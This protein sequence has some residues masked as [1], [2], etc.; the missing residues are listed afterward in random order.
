MKYRHIGKSDIKVST[1]AM[2][3]WAIVGGF[4]WGPQDKTDAE[5]A[6]AAALDAGI[7][8][9][10]TAEGYGDG[11]SEEFLGRMLENRRERVVIATKVSGKNL[12]PANLKKA[13]ENSLRRLRTSYIDL[14]QIHWP[15]RDVPITDT[16]KAMEE[17]QKEGKIRVAACSNFGPADLSDALAAGR[18]E[19]NQVAYNLL[20]RGIEYRLRQQCVENEISILPYSPLAQGLLTG[21]FPTPDHVPAE[22]AR[23]RHFGRERPHTR[24]GENGAEEAAF[25]AIRKISEICEDAGLPMTQTALAYLLA[26]PAVTSVVCG[27]R[28]AK[29]A[30][31]NAEAADIKLSRRVIDRLDEATDPLKAHFGPAMDPWQSKER[32]R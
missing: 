14:Y 24:H 20:W 22:R 21:K 1:V 28:S 25:R 8:F 3:C 26:R 32:I 2:G 23:T 12:P 4:T 30:R 29:Q 31:Q 15:N 17:L 18:L 5:Q 11:Y 13:C 16:M 19:S 27:M 7:N 9:F 6:V 10:D